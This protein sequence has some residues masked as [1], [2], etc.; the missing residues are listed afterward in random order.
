MS[1]T[2]GHKSL[3]IMLYRLYFKNVSNGNRFNF[4]RGLNLVVIAHL[5]YG[6]GKFA[7]E[8]AK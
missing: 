2:V 4:V 7:Y 8:L 3:E 6:N 1:L 5:S